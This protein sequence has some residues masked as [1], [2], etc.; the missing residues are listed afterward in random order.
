MPDNSLQLT[1]D[2]PQSLDQWVFDTIVP[3]VIV[4]DEIMKQL[5]SG[6]EGFDRYVH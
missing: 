4:I 5:L 2:S 3:V 1:V 6:F